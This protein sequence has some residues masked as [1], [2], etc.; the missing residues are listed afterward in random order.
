MGILA[1]RNGT[2]AED[3][4]SSNINPLMYRYPPKQGNFFSSYFIMGGE[5][6]E[7]Q[8]PET[9]L[10]GD[11]ADLNFLGTRPIPVTFLFSNFATFL[12]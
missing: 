2:V 9:Y 5:R 12:V 7:A 11:N 1:S 4:D 6:F 10:F 8:Q 3:V